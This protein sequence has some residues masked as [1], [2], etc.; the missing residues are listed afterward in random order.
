MNY[1]RCWLFVLFFIF[2]SI[3]FFKFRQVSSFSVSSNHVQFSFHKSAQIP[4][5]NSIQRLIEQFHKLFNSIF[6]I[7]LK[8]R[9]EIQ[10]G[11]WVRSFRSCSIQFF[12]F[13]KQ[14]RNS[15]KFFIQYLS[16]NSGLFFSSSRLTIY[17]SVF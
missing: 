17:F 1:A 15:A 13:R 10:F 8:F 12:K 5:R 11:V 16:E 9:Q 2:D 7:F 4:P 3:H 14:A 6:G